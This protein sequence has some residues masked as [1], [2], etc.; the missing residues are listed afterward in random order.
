MGRPP[1]K[2]GA[3]QVTAACVFP[4]TAVAAVGGSGATGGITE[5]DGK[6]AGPVPELLVAVTVNV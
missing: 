2:A 3:S 6:D 4:P 5:L 1:L